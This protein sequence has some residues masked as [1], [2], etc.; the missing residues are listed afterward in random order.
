VVL[1]NQTVLSLF[2]I[3]GLSLL[4]NKSSFLPGID[5]GLHRILEWIVL[6]IAIDFF[7]YVWHYANHR[8]PF[9]WMFHKVH[10]S[11]K[12]VNV[13]TA[14]RFHAGELVFT[15]LFKLML[16]NVAG[17]PGNVLVVSQIFTML[18]VMFHHANVRFRGERFLSRLIV[19][20]FLHR[21][22][23]S[24][25]HRLH[26]KNFGS[27]LIIWDRIFDTLEPAG[28]G[29]YGLKGVK[30]MEFWETFI[31]GLPALNV[32]PSAMLIA[33]NYGRAEIVA[34]P[35][36][37]HFFNDSRRGPPAEQISFLILWYNWLS[38][39]TVGGLYNYSQLIQEN[40]PDPSLKKHTVEFLEVSKAVAESWVILGLRS[41]QIP[42]PFYWGFFC[43]TSSSGVSTPITRNPSL[44]FGQS[45]HTKKNVSPS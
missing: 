23:H 27:V 28:S 4:V 12:C 30:E 36:E 11:D 6:L 19:V 8:I 2:S 18:F 25:E 44:P 35:S 31:F 29:N 7:M 24:V 10:H 39:Q 15:L 14:F 22:H 5:Q 1:I 40:K 37:K 34:E 45:G 13:S 9:L 21:V 26:D 32:Q 3:A 17:I 20:P 38:E 42:M 43:N 16:A 41:A 33:E